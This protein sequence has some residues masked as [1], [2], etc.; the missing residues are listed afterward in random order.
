MRRPHRLRVRR[1]V[2][3]EPA[4]APAHDQ[5]ALV[6]RLDRLEKMVEGLQDSV[7]RETRRHDDR[8]DELARKLEP[9]ELVRALSEDARKRGI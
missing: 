1:K 8:M 3:H 4:S 6:A 5:Q 9:S 2:L 7:D